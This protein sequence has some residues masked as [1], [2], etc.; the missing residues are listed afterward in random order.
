M[1]YSIISIIKRIVVRYEL[2]HFRSLLGY[3]DKTAIVSVPF[4]CSCPK[5]IFLYENT[6]ILGGADFII[7]PNGDR[8]N[9]IMKKYSGASRNLVVITGLH[10]YKV[11]QWSRYIVL[12]RE[13]DVD[14]DVVVEEDVRIGANVTLLPGVTVGRGS[15]IGA[16][17][18]VS[19]DV[20]P[21]SVVAGN[22]AHVHRFKFTKDEILQHES[23]LYPEDKRLTEELIEK[24]FQKYLNNNNFR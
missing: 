22:P 2:K 7:N 9:F 18:V 6:S 3:C 23:S 20:P 14:K 13:L 8:G 4:S 5:K 16:C 11:G 19:R 1:L 17:S 12:S 15:I 24:N 10:G 21:Y